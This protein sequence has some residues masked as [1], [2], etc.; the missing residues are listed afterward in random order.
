MKKTLLI[1]AG[2]SLGTAAIAQD[3]PSTTTTDAPGATTPG[4]APMDP[5][6]PDTGAMTPGAT[7]PGMGAP[8]TAPADPAMSAP[9]APD[10]AMTS[11]S[12]MQSN[13]TNPTPVDS[14]NLPRCSRSVTD[15]CVQGG[16]RRRR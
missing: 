5:A 9:P 1:L 15:K 6:T 16:G 12:G 4:I 14:A 7:D 13:M 2:L 10:A 8:T 3:M 11:S